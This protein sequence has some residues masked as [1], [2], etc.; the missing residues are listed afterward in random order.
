[1]LQEQD[2]TLLTGLADALIELY[3]DVGYDNDEAVFAVMTQLHRLAHDLSNNKHSNE[4]MSSLSI[5]CS[6]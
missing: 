2:F 1:M 6:E 3:P 5:I 4:E